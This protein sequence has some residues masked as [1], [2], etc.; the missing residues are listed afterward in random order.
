LRR[1]EQSLGQLRAVWQARQDAERRGERLFREG[2]MDP[3]Q[4]VGLTKAQHAARLSLTESA[5]AVSL[6]TLQLYRSL[7][8][9]WAD[10]GMAGL[11][12]ETSAPIHAHRSHP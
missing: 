10:Q 12:R 7:G 11:N 3:L 4:R 6:A 5:L 1:Q 9:G 2:L 8:G